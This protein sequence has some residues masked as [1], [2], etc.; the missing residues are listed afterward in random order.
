MKCFPVLIFLIVLL[1]PSCNLREREQQVLQKETSLKEKEQELLLKEKSLSV[2]EEDLL[3][4]ERKLD[5]SLYDTAEVYN[6]T[7]V[8]QWVVQMACTETTCPGSAVGDTKTEQWK[9]EYKGRQIIARA[10][11]GGLLTRVYSGIFTGNTIELVEERKREG[12]QPS[13]KM[14][15]RLRLV[16]DKQM[17]GQREITRNTGCKIIYALQMTKQE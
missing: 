7:L 4:R 5:S 13:A 1:A 11:S 3:R 14:V 17:E 6:D 2:K 15:V 16:N 12:A 8:G 9:I 10:S